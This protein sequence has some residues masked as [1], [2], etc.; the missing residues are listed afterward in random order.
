M[1][2]ICITIIDVYLLF[3]P[4]LSSPVDPATTAADVAVYDYYVD[5]QRLATELSGKQC[6]FASPRYRLSFCIILCI[7]HLLLLLVNSYSM[8]SLFL[9]PLDVPSFILCCL[10]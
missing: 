4:P 5:D 6:P 7:R 1:S 10:L 9:S 3:L 2:C 8:H